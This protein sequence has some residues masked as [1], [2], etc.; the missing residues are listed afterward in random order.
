MANALAVG[1]NQHGL[2]AELFTRGKAGQ[3]ENVGKSM[4]QQH[5]EKMKIEKEQNAL[6]KLA[7]FLPQLGFF[8]RLMALRETDWDIERAL[9]ILRQFAAENDVKLKV[10]HKVSGWADPSTPAVPAPVAVV[11]VCG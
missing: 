10:L 11:A 8:T 2:D 9:G 3:T 6:Q 1:S 4:V 5:I 7:I